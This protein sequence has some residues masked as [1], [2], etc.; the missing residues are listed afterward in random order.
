VPSQAENV[1]L[2]AKTESNRR[3]VNRCFDAQ[4]TEAESSCTRSG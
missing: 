1:R 2:P 4:I 3:T